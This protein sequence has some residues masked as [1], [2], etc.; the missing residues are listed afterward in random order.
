DFRI[1]LHQAAQRGVH[2]EL[3]D[4]DE[5]RNIGAALMM[6]D[7]A[8]DGDFDP[9]H[10]RDGEVGK[11]DLALEVS[12]KAFLGAVAENGVNLR[13]HDVEHDDRREQQN[14]E[15]DYDGG[16]DDAPAP[17]HRN[18]PGQRRL[19][20]PAYYRNRGSE[21]HTANPAYAEGLLGETGTS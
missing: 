6:Q 7:E 11:F 19:G 2:G 4:L 12:A 10:E 20:R 14:R 18:F 1:G 13:R 16:D 17:G 9:G 21:F 5:R 8:R 3:V 15:D